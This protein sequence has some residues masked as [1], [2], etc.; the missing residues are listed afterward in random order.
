M[1]ASKTQVRYM[2]QHSAHKPYLLPA[3][4]DQKPELLNRNTLTL[5]HTLY[6]D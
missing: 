5:T 1:S 4:R 6:C 2:L 3:N